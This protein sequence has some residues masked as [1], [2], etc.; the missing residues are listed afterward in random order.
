MANV[1]EREVNGYPT[2]KPAPGH[3][4]YGEVFELGDTELKR[5]DKWEDRYRRVLV[6]LM[7]GELAYAYVLK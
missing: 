7:S 1:L 2:L 3:R 4:V 6:R 5:L